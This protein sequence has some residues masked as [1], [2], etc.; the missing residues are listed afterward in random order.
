M[1]RTPRSNDPV[2]E[3]RG[4]TRC[5]GDARAPIVALDDVTLSLEPGRVTSILGPNGAGKTTAVKLMLGLLRPTRGQVRLLG[6]DPGDARSRMRL[7]TM[8]QVTGLPDTLRVRELVRLFQTYY[9]RPLP[10]RR[11][12]ELAGLEEVEGRLLG[13][14]SGGQK[15]RV[16]FAL[17]LCG[18]PELLFLDEPT[19]G[20][21]VEARR[22]F[23]TGVRELVD[24]G[25]SV[26]LT[27]HYLEEADALSDRIVVLQ[28]GRVRADGTPHQIKAQAATRRIRCVT[29][30]APGEIGLLAEVR[31]ARWDKAAVEVLTN[32]AEAVVRELLAR[33]PEL[34]ELEVTGSGIEDA[35][36]ALVGEPAGASEAGSE[37]AA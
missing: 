29:R 33:D 27:T 23:W 15:Q 26:V 2:A 8:L 21:D 1:R 31:S 32:E 37:S 5:F 25:R 18:D 19:A 20:L 16:A 28:R 14:L 24:D 30:L 11:V 35:F 17:A 36:L 12:V 3:L 13:K 34:R 22:R 9:P 10:Y 4:V 7:G 6:G